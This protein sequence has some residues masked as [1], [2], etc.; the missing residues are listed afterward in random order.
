MAMKK[1]KKC[2]GSVSSKAKACPHCGARVASSNH[3]CLI[4]ALVLMGVFIVFSVAIGT[5]ATPP[6]G[7]EKPLIEINRIT[8]AFVSS[9]DSR[10]KIE[11]ASAPSSGGAY[12]GW[13]GTIRLFGPPSDFDG[14]LLRCR[15]FS[16]ML[17][18]EVVDRGETNIMK[19]FFI[20]N[21]NLLTCAVGNYWPGELRRQ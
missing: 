21:E 8:G 9:S 17:A 2:G 11:I 20:E 19:M 1:C 16:D 15:I 12:G 4:T 7:M 6:A 14:R 10:W 18:V 5:V 13:N 3:G